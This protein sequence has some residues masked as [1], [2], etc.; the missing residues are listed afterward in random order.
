MGTDLAPGRHVLLLM[1]DEST[2]AASDEVV[3][4]AGR[5]EP[6][7]VDVAPMPSGPVSPP[8]II[9]AST[10]SKAEGVTVRLNGRNITGAFTTRGQLRQGRLGAHEGLKRGRNQLEITA[11]DRSGNYDVVTRTLDVPMTD[12]VAGAGR[13][14]VARAGQTIA[15]DSSS[16][17]SSSGSGLKHEWTIASAPPGAQAQLTKATSPKPEVRMD[18]PGTYQLRLDVSEG[19]GTPS[20]VVKRGTDTVSIAVAPAD[21]P[22]G[23]PIETMTPGMDGISVAGKLDVSGGDW[24]QVVVLNQADRSIAGAQAFNLTDA[25]GPEEFSA[26]TNRTPTWQGDP[27][28]IVTGAGHKADKLSKEW[29]TALDDAWKNLGGTLRTMNVPDPKRG[30]DPGWASG[31]W[32][33]IGIPG[34]EEGQATQ[35]D[36]STSPDSSAGDLRGY[37]QADT[38]SQ[39]NFS[40]SDYIPFDTRVPGSPVDTN[41]VM[42][43]GAAYTSEAVRNGFQVVVLNQ[44]N[45]QPL[46]GLPPSRTFDSDT[47]AGQEGME[48]Y[49]ADALGPHAPRALVIVQSI[50]LPWPTDANER[51]F[52]ITT[53]IAKLGGTT[54][55]FK[56]LGEP[57][58]RADAYDPEG[59]ALVGGFAIPRTQAGESFRSEALNLPH[60]ARLAGMLGRNRQGQ[61]RVAQASPLD[62]CPVGQPSCPTG[63]LDYSILALAYQAPTPF[64]KWSAEQAAAAAWIALRSAGLSRAAF[65]TCNA[66]RGFP[67]RRLS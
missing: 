45:L 64:P 1:S 20:H 43:G 14:R 26:L 40:F 32:S 59:Y 50:G 16:S 29:L 49:L 10:K 22:I 62:A 31:E 51:W 58:H 13:D 19:A 54:D 28:T 38:H 8:V 7:F 60:P 39:Y 2:N 46:A 24:V 33:I 66:M 18:V 17:R 65:F 25:K 56:N 9:D 34:N 55:V 30:E 37:L 42:V 52:P 6:G 47:A 4:I 44:G 5:R 3:F 36:L 23:V 61:L 21:P 12:P 53:Q 27:L 63:S 35:T 11:H 41:R 48:R 67:A 57:H 15:L